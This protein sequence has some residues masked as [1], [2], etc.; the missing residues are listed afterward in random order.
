LSPY[1]HEHQAVLDADYPPNARHIPDAPEWIKV[2]AWIQWERD[3]A[4]W[5]DGYAIGWSRHH[6]LVSIDDARLQVR[7]VWLKPYDV[8][9]R[10]GSSFTGT[11]GFAADDYG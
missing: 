1:G 11:V 4:E 3:E 5:V 8:R 6:V 9:R 10:D 2:E 7:R